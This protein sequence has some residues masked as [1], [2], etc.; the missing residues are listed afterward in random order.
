M[1]Q[2][3]V[4]WVVY[5]FSFVFLIISCAGTELTHKQI[6]EAYKGKPVSNILVIGIT[7]NEDSRRFFER[8]FVAKLK[9]VGVEAISSEDA[10]PMPPDLK[11]TK[12]MILNAVN[13][14]KNDAVIIT[15]L[16]DK[17]EKEVVTRG[18]QAYRG[19]YGFY[20]SRFSYSND[21]GYSS[22][23]KTARLETNLY[24]VKT[25][26]LIWSGQSKTW[27][28]DSKYQIINDVIKVVIDDLQKNKLISPK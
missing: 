17:Q 15:H 16:V 13:Q 24:D 18:G 11:L 12:E 26:Q 9:S 3:S 4:K 14:F 28:K 7:G 22:T 23:S 10:I 8:K 2:N 1:K 25:E 21:P 19:Y 27:S 5:L 6:N 20:Y